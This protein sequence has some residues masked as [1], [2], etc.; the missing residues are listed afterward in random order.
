MIEYL[1]TGGCSFSQPDS[2]DVTWPI[3][4]EKHLGP[5][6]ALHGGR[7]CAD[8]TTIAR[9]AIYNVHKLLRAGVDPEKILVGIMWSS[10]DRHSIYTTSDNFPHNIF[11]VLCAIDRDPVTELPT[12]CHTNPVYIASDQRNQYLMHAS[13]DDP[14]S[15]LYFEHFYDTIG[16]QIVSLENVLRVQWFLKHH[17]IKYFMTEFSWHSINDHRPP[18]DTTPRETLTHPDVAYL[19]EQVDCE[20][21]LPVDNMTDWVEANGIPY[22]RPPD[23]HPSTEA[24]NRFL[25]EIMLP[26]LK[27]RSF[28]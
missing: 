22:S 2:G 16:A 24:H 23:N 8:N 17:G 27:Q 4:L 26:F 28:I 1:V 20:C 18:W 5:K 13:F 3:H 7:G 10:I 19:Q 12:G 9:L 15:K 25:N 6:M 14:S 21:W 11:N